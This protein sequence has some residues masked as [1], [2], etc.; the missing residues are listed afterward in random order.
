MRVAPSV[1]SADYARFGEQVRM[2]QAAGADWLHVDIMDGHFVPNLTFG[3]G[4]VA[5][6]KSLTPLYLDTHLMVTEPWRFAEP[7][8]RAGAGGLTIHVEVGRTAETLREIRA[9]GLRAGVSVKPGTPLE[10]AE[11]FLADIDL[12]LLMT[13][14][15]GFGGQAFREDMLPRIAAAHAARVK[16][17]LNFDLEVD[18]GIGPQTTAAV[19]RAGADA[20]VAGHSV[21]RAPDPAAAIA[22]I[23]A[24]VSTP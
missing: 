24:A 8:A 13:V 20:L 11:P 21:F 6:L 19:T 3:P 2:I 17:G 14:E 4:L 22:A 5:A 23:R 7:F 9:L 1:L 18:G 16:H 12:L 10:L 15:P